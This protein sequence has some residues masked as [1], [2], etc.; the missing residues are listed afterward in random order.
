MSRRR[1]ASARTVP[2]GIEVRHQRSCASAAGKP[3][4][5][6]PT[7]RAWVV[8]PRD[9]RRIRKRFATLEAAKIWREDAT[10]DIRRGV[11]AAPKPLTV[12]AAAEAW[13]KGARPGAV[14]TRSGH[15][16]KP[17]VIRG[18]EQGLRLY[19]LPALD[20]KKLGELRRSDV[21]RFADELIEK[22]M[23]P[24]TVRNALMPLRAI[25]RRALVRGSPTSPRRPTSTRARRWRC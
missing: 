3:C 4:D 2:V 18:Y 5:C 15:L 14:R 16:Y 19:V 22:G 11:L 25:C 10:V 12:G 6:T 7:Y 1:E 23:T 21:Q 20:K 9:K 8:S 17:S 13:L 24:S